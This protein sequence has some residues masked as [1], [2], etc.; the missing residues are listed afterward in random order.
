MSQS[1]DSHLMHKRV[2]LG[3]VPEQ[4]VVPFCGVAARARA[5]A[6]RD[7]TPALRSGSECNRDDTFHR[8]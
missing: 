1:V 7:Y 2:R 3:A 8:L 6:V 4:D 5:R